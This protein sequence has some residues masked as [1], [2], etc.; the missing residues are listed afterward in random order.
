M[1]RSSTRTRTNVRHVL[2]LGLGTWW[3]HPLTSVQRLSSVIVMGAVAACALVTR[4][5][6]VIYTCRAEAGG[7]SAD[8][9]ASTAN[10]GS[11]IKT[12]WFVH[13]LRRVVRK[14]SKLG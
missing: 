5:I 9:M 13:E 3:L 7:P 12:V 14:N 4:A 10:L 11:E 6:Q 1:Q 8:R 2:T